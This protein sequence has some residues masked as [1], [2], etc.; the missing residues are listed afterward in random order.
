MTSVGDQLDM[1]FKAKD[2]DSDLKTKFATW[3]RSRCCC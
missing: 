1:Q 2:A 3:Q